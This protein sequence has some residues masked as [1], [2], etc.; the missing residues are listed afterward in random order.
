MIRLQATQLTQTP[1]QG[2][3]MQ[4]GSLEAGIRPYH[5]Q[6]HEGRVVDAKSLVRAYVG[7]S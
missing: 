7:N 1:Q 4:A 3:K 5:T 2:L 6:V